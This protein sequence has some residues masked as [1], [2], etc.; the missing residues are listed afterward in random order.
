[1]KRRKKLNPNLFFILSGIAVVG[2]GFVCYAQNDSLGAYRAEVVDL[3]TELQRQGNVETQLEEINLKVAES[4][5]KL[6]HL[7][8]GVPERAY[9]PTLMTE[10]EALGQRNGI[11]VTGVRPMPAKFAPP[12]NE[13]P[14]KV[15]KKPYIEQFVEVKGSGHYLKVL[16]FLSQLESFPKIVS[17]Q[18]VTL[19]PKNDLNAEGDKSMLDITIELKAF[20]FHETAPAGG[21][22]TSREN[23]NEGA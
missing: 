11:L 18:T 4:R 6:N 23:N 22:L 21:A 2:W 9:M 3:K 13:D 1:M 16:Q 12:P 7:E 19:S 17:V 10:I 14:S 15:E 8:Q 20:L 5:E